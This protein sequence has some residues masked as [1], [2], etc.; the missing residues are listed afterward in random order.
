MIRRAWAAHLLSSQ[1]SLFFLLQRQTS[2]PSHFHITTFQIADFLDYMSSLFPLEHGLL[3]YIHIVYQ[4]VVSALAGT[5]TH[6]LSLA[7]LERAV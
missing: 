1:L 6:L 3:Q 4:C 5:M 7:F 2:V